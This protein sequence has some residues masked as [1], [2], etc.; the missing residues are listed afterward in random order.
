MKVVIAAVES[1]GYVGTTL[2]IVSFLFQSLIKPRLLNAMGAFFV[3]VYAL[4]TY[5]RPV[6]I[7][8][9]FI[10][11]INVFLLVEHGKKI[12]HS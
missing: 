1:V 6:A 8:G 10:V 3:T 2:I 4:L 9:G 11:I 7:I 5:A 12:A